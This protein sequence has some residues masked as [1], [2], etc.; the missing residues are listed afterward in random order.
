MTKLLLHRTEVVVSL[1]AVASLLLTY[2]VACVPGLTDRGTAQ[3]TTGQTAAVAPSTAGA[4]PQRVTGATV[5]TTPG[6]NFLHT[7]GTKIVDAQGKEFKLTGVSWFGL[8]TDTLSP[9]GLWARNYQEILDQVVKLGYNSIRLPFS[10]HLFND[11]L[12][13]QGIDF[14]LNP[15]LKGL[16][17]LQIM[18]KIIVAAGE[19]GLKIL[20]DQHR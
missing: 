13:P 15:D 7:D 14:S 10:N 16:N 3:P 12:K 8:E 19:R 17:G 4:A 9:H 11:N 6:L 20:L 2:G 5:P 1:V 18:D